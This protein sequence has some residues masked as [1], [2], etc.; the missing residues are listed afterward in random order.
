MPERKENLLNATEFAKLCGVSA[1]TILNW[2]KCGKLVPEYVQGRYNFFARSQFYD[3]LVDMNRFNRSFGGLALLFGSEEEI[4]A[5]ENAFIHIVS[6]SY[7]NACQVESITDALD[8]AVMFGG[9]EEHMD[10]CGVVLESAHSY[11]HKELLHLVADIIDRTESLHD[12]SLFSIVDVALGRSDL[13][14]DGYDTVCTEFENLYRVVVKRYGIE[15]LLNQCGHSASDLF[16][17]CFDMNHV[18]QTSSGVVYSSESTEACAIWEKFY[19]SREARNFKSRVKRLFSDGYYAVMNCGAGLE[20][21]I[22]D[23]IEYAVVHGYYDFVFVNDIERLPSCLCSTLNSLYRCG[24]INL[25]TDH[26]VS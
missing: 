16:D 26:Q 21:S 5:G 11:Y 8:D 25:F 10:L 17:G 18:E 15:S 7:K 9:F 3:V 4:S 24:H 12:V 2:V 1:Q 19:E 13:I 23:S 20:E 6:S 22:A 14:F